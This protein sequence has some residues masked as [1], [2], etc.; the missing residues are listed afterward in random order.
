MLLILLTGNYKYVEGTPQKIWHHE[1]KDFFNEYV[2]IK[3]LKIE[4]P[5]S[6][7]MKMGKHYLIRYLPNS[8]YGIDVEEI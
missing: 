1:G 3:G 8:G 7:T 6:S 2:Q 4:F 5:I